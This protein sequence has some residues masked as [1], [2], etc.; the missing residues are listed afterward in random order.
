M[1]EKLRP[2]RTGAVPIRPVNAVQRSSWCLLL[3]LCIKIL[4]V[5]IF[6]LQ[7]VIDLLFRVIVIKTSARAFH[8]HRLLLYT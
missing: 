7:C 1:D 2:G 5:A 8:L 6:V 3:L 4:Q